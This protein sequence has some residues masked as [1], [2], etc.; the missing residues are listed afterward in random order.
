MMLDLYFQYEG[1]Q[2]TGTA[3]RKVRPASIKGSSENIVEYFVDSIQ[4]EDFPLKAITFTANSETPSLSF[5]NRYIT[6]EVLPLVTTLSK[7]VIQA[8][9]NAGISLFE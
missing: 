5:N 1:K 3:L 6:T 2:Y 9:E 7:A 8:C 4:P